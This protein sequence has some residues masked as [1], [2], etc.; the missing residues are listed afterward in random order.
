M[1]PVILSTLKMF[2]IYSNYSKIHMGQGEVHFLESLLLSDVIKEK[3]LLHFVSAYA[4]QF[5]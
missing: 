5:I 1:T 2:K 3:Y 4:K